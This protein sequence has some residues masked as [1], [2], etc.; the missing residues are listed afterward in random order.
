V[1]EFGSE[2]NPAG[3]CLH[4]CDPGR[5]APRIELEPVVVNLPADAILQDDGEWVAAKHRRPALSE[6]LPS[7]RLVARIE[8]LFGVIKHEN[9]KNSV[10]RY[11]ALR[12]RGQCSPRQCIGGLFGWRPLRLSPPIMI[13]S[14]RAAGWQAPAGVVTSKT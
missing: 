13:A 14:D 10:A 9:Q 4:D 12:L 11:R 1:R 3:S 2:Y 7:A 6:Q 5:L 8:R